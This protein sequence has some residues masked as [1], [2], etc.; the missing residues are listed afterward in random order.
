MET[1]EILHL[2]NHPTQVRSIVRRW[3]VNT[4]KIA[5]A[6]LGRSA[7]KEVRRVIATRQNVRHLHVGANK[8][9]KSQTGQYQEEILS[10]LFF[11]KTKVISLTLLRKARYNNICE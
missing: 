11:V 1:M 5:T 3:N 4:M 9:I 6:M 2:P 10:C 7:W 8:D